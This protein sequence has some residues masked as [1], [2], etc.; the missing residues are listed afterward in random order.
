MKIVF[1]NIIYSLQKSGG[2]SVYWTE[3]IKR[4]SKMNDDTVFFDQ[5][6]PNDNI[7]RKTV[8]FKNVKTESKWFLSIRRYLPFSEKIK[9]KFIFHSSYFSSET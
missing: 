8:D 3:L 6:E 2:G 1:D 5:K 9:G 4:F 7:F